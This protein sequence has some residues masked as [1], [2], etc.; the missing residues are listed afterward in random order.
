MKVNK[1]YIASD[2]AGFELKR[3]ILLAKLFATYKLVDLGCF[4]EEPVDY[5]DYVIKMAESFQDNST[6]RGVL[7]CGT[8]IG[9]S[10]AANRFPYIR[11]ALCH[12][13]EQVILARE[14]NDANILVFGAKYIQADTAIKCLFTFLNTDFAGGRHLRR[15]K[16]LK[17]L[18]KL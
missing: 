8:G 1:I 6:I 17:N 14:H 3:S 12:T 10:I 13:E 16:K 7:I 4:N 5:P 15:V 11:A 9:V 2:H 18:T